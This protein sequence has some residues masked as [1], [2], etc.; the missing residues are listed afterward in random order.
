[1][2]LLT[3]IIAIIIA[4]LGCLTIMGLMFKQNLELRRENQRLIDAWDE[5]HYDD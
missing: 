2:L 1:M 4:L 5:A 3:D